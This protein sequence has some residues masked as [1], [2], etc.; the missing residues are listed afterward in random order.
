MVLTQIAGPDKEKTRAG[1]VIV[2]TFHDCQVVFVEPGRAL[3]LHR[4]STRPGWV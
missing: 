2:F 3:P 4:W 1:H